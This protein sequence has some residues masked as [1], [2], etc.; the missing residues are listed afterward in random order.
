[1][2]THAEFVSDAFPPY[3]EEEELI[4]PGVY[5]KRLAEFLADSLKA[6]GEKVG[7]LIAED[8]GW[9]VPVENDAFDLWVGAG[10]YEE[11]ENGFLCFIQPHKEYVRRFFKKIDTSARVRGLQKKLNAALE[12]HSSVHGL[13]W[14]SY[15]EFSSAS[16]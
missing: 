6:S 14:S 2:L 11:R 10:N 9:V 7:E 1:M 8:W 4:N 16:S 5:G 3:D 12:G 15:D 13:K